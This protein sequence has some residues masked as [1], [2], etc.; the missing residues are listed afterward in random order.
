MFRVRFDFVDYALFAQQSRRYDDVS[1]EWL[2]EGQHRT[3]A[4]S[5]VCDCLAKLFCY[6]FRSHLLL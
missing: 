2:T 5:D 1:S 4:E 3:G 6:K